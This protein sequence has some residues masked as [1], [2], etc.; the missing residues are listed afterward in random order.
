MSGTV[1]VIACSTCGSNERDAEGRT[2]GERLVSLLDQV[3]RRAAPDSAAASIRVES[4]RCLW[5]CANRC[6]VHLRS[7]GR[8]GY[9]I[10][11]LEPTPEVA[12]ALVEY[13]ER[14]GE[15]DEGAVP[16]KQ[17]PA[18]LKGHFLARIPKTSDATSPNDDA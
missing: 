1:E 18:A 8:V 5:A 16:F 12:E 17:W 2:K 9:V 15:S 10:G 14:Y 4:V 6:A 11:K 7:P 13:A 3:R